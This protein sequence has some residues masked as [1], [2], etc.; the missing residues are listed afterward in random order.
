MSL[1]IPF[2]DHVYPSGANFVL[3]SLQVSPDASRQLV[4]EL[5]RE[6]IYVKDVSNKFEDG[7][8]YWRLAVRLPSENERLCEVLSSSRMRERFAEAR[9]TVTPFGMG[10]ECAGHRRG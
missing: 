8:S 5:L 6:S 4:D 1:G 2:I 10:C 3:A 7:R 9:P